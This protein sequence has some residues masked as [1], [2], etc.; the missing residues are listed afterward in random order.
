M[1]KPSPL[2][3][4]RNL[5]AALQ[6][7]RALQLNG[8]RVFLT[9]DFTRPER[10]ILEK[11]GFLQRVIAG[12]YIASAPGEGDGDTTAWHASFR[13]FIGAYGDHRFQARWCL[14]AEGSVLMHAGVTTLPSQIVMLAEKA[15]RNVLTLPGGTSLLDLPPAFAE[16]LVQ[17]EQIGAVRVLSLPLALVRV[18]EVFF[19]TYT[20]DAQVALRQIRSASQ[21][22]RILLTGGHPT[23][24]GRL[25]GAF[26]AIGAPLIAD[27]IVAVMTDGGYRVDEKNPFPHEVPSLGRS[28]A[29]SPYIDRIRIMWQRM[30]DDVLRAFPPEPG[31][32]SN[33]A[34]YMHAVEDAYKGDAY[35]SL[36]IEGY[37]VTESLIERVSRGA[38]NPDRHVTDAESRNAMAAHG[39]YLAHRAA[40]ESIAEILS[41]TNA[42]KVIER[43]HGRWYRELFKPSVTARVLRDLD[44]AGYRNDQVFIRNAEH[45]PPHHSAVLDMMPTLFELLTEES[46]AAVRAV[47]GHFV[48]VFIHPYMDGNG[49]MGRFVMNA[50]LASGGFPWTVIPVARRDEYLRA[51]DAASRHGDITPFARFVASCIGVTQVAER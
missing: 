9:K 37:A 2:P 34:A 47:L 44:L 17:T 31:L 33:H 1:P 41:G 29:V 46:S 35:H 7:M 15:Q 3:A 24:A 45:V 11:S 10:E 27:E 36:S 22:T 38:W 39:Y 16:D 23:I 21:L 14:S 4:Q 43:D 5:A 19:R 51:L 30:R 40:S 42:G 26:R 18:Q 50:M 28:R 13:D 12:W 25:A 6:R 8:R 32:P 49:R 20:M 48:F